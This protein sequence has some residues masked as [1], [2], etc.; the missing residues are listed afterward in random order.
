[1]SFVL[2]FVLLVAYRFV[3]SR[4]AA[5]VLALLAVPFTVSPFYFIVAKAPLE[6]PAASA[7]TPNPSN[8][9]EFR[10][11]HAFGENL[12]Y[13]DPW[14]V[15]LAFPWIGILGVLTLVGAALE[16]YRQP[17]TADREARRRQARRNPFLLIAT[18][19]LGFF[20]FAILSTVITGVV[21]Q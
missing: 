12:V 19:F 15:T 10:F 8:T 16:I 2:V 9:T 5:I 7:K 4:G 11:S 1:M 17:K 20:V 14:V 21:A 6:E 18:V 13:L 3:P